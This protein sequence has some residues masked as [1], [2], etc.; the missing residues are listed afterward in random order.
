MTVH[1]RLVRRYIYWINVVDLTGVNVRPRLGRAR[2]ASLFPVTTNLRVA[3]CISPSWSR[4][5]HSRAALTSRESGD[6]CHSQIITVN[7]NWRTDRL[8]RSLSRRNRVGFHVYAQF[9]NRCR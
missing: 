6:Y 1:V 8:R 4:Y 9:Q 3:T 5:P 7:C 2:R